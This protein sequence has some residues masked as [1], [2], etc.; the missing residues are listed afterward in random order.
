MKKW[1]YNS[2]Y[3]AAKSCKT[4]AEFINTGSAYVI[5]K[6][7]GWLKDYVWLES[8]RKPTGYWDSF[9]NCFE[10][11]KKYKT[12]SE[13]QNG[14]SAAYIS[15]SKNGWLDTWFERKQKPNGYWNSYENCYEEAKK[16]QY[17]EEFRRGNSWAYKCA[18]KNGWL[19]DYTWFE[20]KIMPN[21]Y[22]GK[23]RC[24]N[25][26][27]KYKSRTEFGDNSPGAYHA[28]K[29]NGWI[30]DYTWFSK[31]IHD[32]DTYCVYVYEHAKTN[33]VYVG[34]TFHIKQRHF[35][36]K[37]G[38]LKNGVRH[39]DTV[40]KYFRSIGEKLP[41]PRIIRDKLTAEQAQYFEDY[42]INYY[43]ESGITVLNAIK[44]GSLGGTVVV[45][46]KEACHNEAKKYKSRI[47]FARKN[48]AAYSA[49]WKSGWLQDYTWFERP[50]NPN[51]KWDYETCFQEAKK[52]KTKKEFHDGSAGAYAIA[53]KNGWLSEYDWFEKKLKWNRE[54]CYQEA[55]KYNCRKEFSDNSESAYKV[56]LQNGWLN[57]YTWFNPP[58]TWRKNNK[59]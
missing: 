58:A 32:K 19:D 27:L 46:T 42:Y 20:R 21:G 54:T 31:P 40:A 44:A 39:Y 12:I 57:D 16:Y 35:E 7:N 22:W 10:E 33:T 11:A 45:W 24:Y 41:E 15:A 9:D 59:D 52:Y 14:C 51:K 49:A 28:A 30:E 34:I 55:L 2:C 29:T 37:N 23:E 3:A 50:K 26:A 17:R 48:P 4:K 38:K 1:D 43:R 5:A 25:E 53:W 47:A 56:A 36:H 18:K 8:S 6:R 13:F